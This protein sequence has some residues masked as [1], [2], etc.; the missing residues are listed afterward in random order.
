MT[1]PRH[2]MP[3]AEF[4]RLVNDL[5]ITGELRDAIQR[6]RSRVYNLLMDAGIWPEQLGGEMNA[7]TKAAVS[8][9]L[10]SHLDG[11]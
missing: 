4:W 7:E 10:R 3:T 9:A 1:D 6:E 2:V 11:E 5:A 8:K